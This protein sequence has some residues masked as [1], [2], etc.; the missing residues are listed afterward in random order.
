MALKGIVIERWQEAH[1]EIP[2]SNYEKV[3]SNYERGNSNYERENANK[4]ERVNAN[5]ERVNSNNRNYNHPDDHFD[6][7]NNQNLSRV[8]SRVSAKYSNQKS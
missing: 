6:L 3:N 7:K 1:G 8:D 2:S 5:Y 4:F